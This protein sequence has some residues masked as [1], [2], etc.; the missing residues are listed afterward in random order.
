MAASCRRR[1]RAY[2]ELELRGVNAKGVA[3]LQKGVDDKLAQVLDA[4]QKQ[5]IK[6]MQQMAARGGPRGFGP[7]GPRQ[8]PRRLP[9]FGGLQGGQ[10]VFRAYRYGPDYSGLAGK[11]LTPGKTIEELESKQP[12]KKD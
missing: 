3:A 4:A 2:P 8:G 1:H 5:R 11:D 12:A 7:G 9:G 10:P 6:E